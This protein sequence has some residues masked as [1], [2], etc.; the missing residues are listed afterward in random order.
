MVLMPSEQK[1]GGILQFMVLAFSFH[2]WPDKEWGMF[3]L[4]FVLLCVGSWLCLFQWNSFKFTVEGK[5][6]FLVKWLLVSMSQS[7]LDWEMI[8]HVA[9]GKKK[10]LIFFFLSYGHVPGMTKKP[11]IVGIYGIYIKFQ[12]LYNGRFSMRKN[13]AQ[14]E[15]PICPTLGSIWLIYLFNLLWRQLVNS[16]PEKG[17]SLTVHNT[18]IFIFHC[19]VAL[20]RQQQ[21]QW[22]VLLPMC[23]HPGL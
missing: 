4:H 13:M 17:A 12:T 10:V 19:G 2:Y 21:Q 15:S 14:S 3:C 18:D 16:V 23:L 9:A 1:C 5:P 11:Y 6:N 22:R 20:L 7:L 8:C